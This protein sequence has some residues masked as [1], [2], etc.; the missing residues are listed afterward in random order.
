M[1]GVEKE[2]LLKHW[3][4]SKILKNFGDQ[5]R[6]HGQLRSDYWTSVQMF[7]DHFPK[8]F[9][10]SIFHDATFLEM[11]SGSGCILNMLSAYRPAK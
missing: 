4:K 6:I 7:R 11:G 3:K 10:F 5:W 1:D 8:D 2:S 9:D